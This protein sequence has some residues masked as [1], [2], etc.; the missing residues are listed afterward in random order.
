MAG[1]ERTNP[2]DGLEQL[3]TGQESGLQMAER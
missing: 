3:L 2:W 1:E